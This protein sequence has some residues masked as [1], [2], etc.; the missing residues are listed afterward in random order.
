[1]YG[2]LL[3][4]IFLGNYFYGFLSKNVSQNMWSSIIKFLKIEM[5]IE[6][7]AETTIYLQSLVIH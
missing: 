5:L 4:T 2:Y 6:P 7:N 3:E 1:M